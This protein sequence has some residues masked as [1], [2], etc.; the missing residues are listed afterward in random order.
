MKGYSTVRAVIVMVFCVLAAATAIAVSRPISAGAVKPD[1]SCATSTPC[2]VEDNTG[3]GQAVSTTAYGNDAIDGV[4]YF[5]S[6][7]SGVAGVR[8]EDQS[9]NNGSGGHLNAG[10][11]GASDFG[12]GISAYSA[13]YVGA[14]ISGGAYHG[15]YPALSV[16]GNQSGGEADLID[17][18]GSGLSGPCPFTS[19]VFRLD[20]LGA[21]TVNDKSSTHTAV[22]INSGA[23]TNL[24]SVLIAQSNSNGAL[25]SL[26]GTGD[27]T[28]KGTLTQMGTPLIMNQSNAGRQ[29]ITFAGQEAS[30]SIEDVGEAM[31]I[32]GYASVQIDPTFASTMDPQTS[33][34]VFVTPEGDS[35][36]L[37][38]TAK[39]HA[40]FVV[41]ENRGGNSSIEFS[42]RIVGK[43]AGA[44]RVRLPFADSVPSIRRFESM[45]AAE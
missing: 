35:N 23:A 8:G 11:A 30:P 3:T 43:P 22:L 21:V 15:K 16:R 6:T 34:V 14:D 41:R 19:A 9:N 24:E 18:C 38:V 29:V 42:Y 1:D 28:I 32:R 2:L 36:G 45:D 10:V 31:L 44:A 17:A 12:L 25:M 27:L 26:D 4:T 20:Y 5:D 33:Y 40:G 13:N 7:T 39:T 37:Y